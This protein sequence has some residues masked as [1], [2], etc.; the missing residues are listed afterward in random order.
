MIVQLFQINPIYNTLASIKWLI[1]QKDTEKSIK[2]IDAFISL[3]R[4]TI[5][6]TEQFIPVHKEMENLKNY[7]LINN[8]RYGDR[9]SV[10]FFV[11]PDCENAL[12]PKMILQPFIENAFFHAFPENQTGR[13][14]VFVKNKQGRLLICVEDDGIGIKDADTKNLAKDSKKGD[15][16]SGIGI[17]NVDQRL[18]LLY[19]KDAGITIKSEEKIGTKIIVEIPLEKT[20]SESERKK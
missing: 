1:W 14:Q 19:G 2:T 16:F 9:V 17:G 15:Y 12:V 7:I 8:T 10:E 3:L 18:K 6:D 20:E 4:N 5:S 11:L 13:I